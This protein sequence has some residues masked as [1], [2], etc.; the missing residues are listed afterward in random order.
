MLLA[1]QKIYEELQKKKQEIEK[2]KMT[3]EY[4][5]VYLDKMEHEMKIL[6]DFINA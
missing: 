6:Q 4:K 5:N 1:I 2:T 3:Q